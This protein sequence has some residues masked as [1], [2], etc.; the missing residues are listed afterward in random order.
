M[1]TG[2]G[3]KLP[4]FQPP[5]AKINDLSLRAFNEMSVMM[6]MRAQLE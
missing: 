6:Q 5:I 4:L 1:K 3:P 2:N